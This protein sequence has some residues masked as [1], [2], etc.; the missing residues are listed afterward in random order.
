MKYFNDL[1]SI[2]DEYNGSSIKYDCALDIIEKVKSKKKVV[3]FSYTITPLE[4]LK[5]LLD[6]EFSKNASLIFEGS[7]DLSSRNKAIENF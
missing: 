5:V 2:C 3:V 6:K 7:M 4:S 1:R